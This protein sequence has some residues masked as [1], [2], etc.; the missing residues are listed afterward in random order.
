MPLRASRRQFEVKAEGKPLAVGEAMPR[1]DF[2]TADPEY[3]RAAGIPLLKGR[4]FA[5]DRS[6]RAPA[7]S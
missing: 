3:F 6:R 2:R 7:G 5:V 4:A 1:A